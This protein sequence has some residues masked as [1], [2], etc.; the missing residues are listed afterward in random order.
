MATSKITR[1]P[2]EVR[3]QL[4]R[5]LQNGERGKP[6]VAW[7]N[8]LPSVRAVM[9]MEFGGKPAREKNLSYEWTSEAARTSLKWR[10]S[11]H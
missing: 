4:N 8:S 2:G 9:E 5:P 7:L 6:L 3:E 1:L 10:E 11:I